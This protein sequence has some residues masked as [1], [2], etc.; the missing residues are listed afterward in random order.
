MKKKQ[1][2]G[3]TRLSFLALAMESTVLFNVDD[4]FIIKTNIVN[5]RITILK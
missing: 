4:F 2:K 1:E 5:L 3:R